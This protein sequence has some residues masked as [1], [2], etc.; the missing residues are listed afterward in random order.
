M[1]PKVIVVGASMGGLHALQVLLQGLPKEFP[2]PIVVVQHR[3]KSSSDAFSALLQQYSSLSISEA[4]DKDALAAGHVYVAPPDYHLLVDQ[5]GL[6]LSTEAPVNYSRPSVDVLF[7]SAAY[8]FGDG[9]VAVVLTGSTQDGARGA[10]LIREKGGV[11][12]VQDPATAEAG[13]MPAAAVAATTADQVL[14]LA[15]IAP[16][17]V[18]LCQTEGT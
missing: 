6:A 7:E 11:V 18:K 9:T 16:Y 14:L 15:D 1:A 2:V 17:L 12:I 10:A 8:E 4:E 5:Q 13:A 3:D